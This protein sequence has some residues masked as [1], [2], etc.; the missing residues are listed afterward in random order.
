MKK[1]IKFCSFACMVLCLTACACRS[2]LSNQTVQD[3]YLPNK[4]HG[5]MKKVVDGD[6]YNIYVDDQNVMYYY[7]EKFTGQSS[8]AVMTVMLNPDGTARIWEGE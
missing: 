7:S 5:C 3:T 1:T 2:E 4:T 8:V 6:G